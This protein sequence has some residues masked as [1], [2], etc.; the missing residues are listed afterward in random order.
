MLVGI[1]VL[2]KIPDGFADENYI[3]LYESIATDVDAAMQA[4]INTVKR[5]N[6]GY[7]RSPA[8]TEAVSLIRY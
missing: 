7:A 5:A 1:S 3:A 4:G 6:V 2:M 8:L